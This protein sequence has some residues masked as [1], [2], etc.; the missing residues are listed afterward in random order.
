M[1]RLR[2]FYNNYVSYPG[3]E[4]RTLCKA[5]FSIVALCFL[6]GALVSFVNH[7]KDS[8]APSECRWLTDRPTNAKRIRVVS[9]DNLVMLDFKGYLRYKANESGARTYYLPIRAHEILMSK[10]N[11][12]KRRDLVLK[13]DCARI[14]AKI[15]RTENKDKDLDWLH[16]ISM[17]V[18]YKRPNEKNDSDDSIMRGD[19]VGMQNTQGTSYRCDGERHFRSQP[20]PDTGLIL[21]SEFMQLECDQTP[22]QL[23]TGQFGR[24]IADCM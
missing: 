22:R 21:V 15:F 18:S 11:S 10:E 23:S 14:E 12:D 8:G 13:T 6:T 7:S 24:V 2:G 9:D 3:F 1:D 17:T 5:F 16:V 19:L 20:K 4:P